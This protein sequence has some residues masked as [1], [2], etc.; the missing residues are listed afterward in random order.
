MIDRHNNASGL[1]EPPGCRVV[2]CLLVFY[3]CADSLE[4]FVLVDSKFPASYITDAGCV[5]DVFH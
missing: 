1:L 4:I 5:P 2:G 3:R